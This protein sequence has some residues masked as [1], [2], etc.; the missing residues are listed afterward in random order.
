MPYT[1]NDGANP[2]IPDGAV[3]AAK[4]IDTFIQD[5][6][7]AYNERLSTA[8]GG[9][10]S[11]ATEADM[12]KIRG[13]ATFHGTGKQT[14]QP[15][16][17]LGNISGNVTIDFDVR[18]NYV[19]GTLTGNVTFTFSNLRP[20]ATYVLFLAQDAT[21]NRTITWPSGVRWP[22]GVAPSINLTA[23]RVSLITLV[24]FSNSIALATLAGTAF[25]VS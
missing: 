16:A 12:D 6:K 7:R 10:W 1:N 4:D 5:I 18:G 24:P 3:A 14:V 19:R 13:V 23:S 15:I 8:F 9:D 25:N 17:E 11:T 21:G 20:G 22:G 2:A